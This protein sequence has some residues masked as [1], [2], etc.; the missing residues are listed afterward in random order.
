MRPLVVTYTEYICKLQKRNTRMSFFLKKACCVVN[1]C[2]QGNKHAYSH[3]STHTCNCT[4]SDKT[5]MC[6]LFFPHLSFVVNFPFS[7]FITSV[8]TNTECDWE[9]QMIIASTYLHSKGIEKLVIT[10]EKKTGT[11]FN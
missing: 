4:H 5:N 9:L 8:F 3:V 10:F 2:E 1:F 6:S 7:H 11:L